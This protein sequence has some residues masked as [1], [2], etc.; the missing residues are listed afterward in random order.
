M[1][2]HAQA[3]FSLSHLNHSKQKWFMDYREVISHAI[4]LPA[5]KID[6]SMRVGWLIHRN[7]RLKCIQRLLF[8]KVKTTNPFHF[9][10]P[11]PSHQ[12]KT[13]YHSN[14][15]CHVVMNRQKKKSHKTVG[16]Q[17]RVFIWLSFI[18]ALRWVWI[19]QYIP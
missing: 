14:V 9:K 10:T 17:R 19:F 5:E 13:V 2:I 11:T 8:F 7:K 16:T 15:E 1:S 18:Q 3:F 12:N 6:W 4:N